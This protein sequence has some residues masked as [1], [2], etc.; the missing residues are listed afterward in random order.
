MYPSVVVGDPFKLQP[1]SVTVEGSTFPVQDAI[2]AV[3]TVF[4]LYWVFN[5]KYAP[6]LTR[7]LSILEHFFGISG[8][9]KRGI[10]VSRVI[11]DI[12]ALCTSRG[13]QREMH[14]QQQGLR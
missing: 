9:L 10:L 4:E 8:K 2:T 11:S 12:S 5:L 3:S 1:C 14:K 7:T 13:H 6:Q